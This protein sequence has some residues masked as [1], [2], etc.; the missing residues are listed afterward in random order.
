[1]TENELV[2]FSE[3]V[4][5]HLDIKAEMKSLK[6]QDDAHKETL[7]VLMMA[8]G[9]EEVDTPHGKVKWIASHNKR[10]DQQKLLEHGVEPG[11]IVASTVTKEYEYLKVVVPK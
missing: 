8:M 3:I 5:S 7:K 10:I 2:E 4:K 6:E 9:A 1:M 11:V